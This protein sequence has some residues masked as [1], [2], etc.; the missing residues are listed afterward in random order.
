MPNSPRHPLFR[1]PLKA[2]HYVGDKTYTSLHATLVPTSSLHTFPLSP[3]LM[4]QPDS[5]HGADLPSFTLILPILTVPRAQLES[6][7]LQET[8]LLPQDELGP[9]FCVPIADV[10]NY[11]FPMSH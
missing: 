11:S 3:G 6:H 1:K 4:L 2:L 7:L 9:L 8:F 10:H 5:N